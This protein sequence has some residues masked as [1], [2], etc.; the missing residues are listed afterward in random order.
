MCFLAF[1]S[2]NHFF[3]VKLWHIL[4]RWKVLVSSKTI[5]ALYRC[6]DVELKEKWRK[7]ADF[8]HRLANYPRFL[9]ILVSGA[10]APMVLM[11]QDKR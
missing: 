6:C 9:T 1:R 10:Y 4:Y 5:L 2:T 8:L 11:P 3:P 7:C